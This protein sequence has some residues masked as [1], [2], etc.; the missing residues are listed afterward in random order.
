MPL[1]QIAAHRLAF[2]SDSWTSMAQD[3]GLIGKDGSNFYLYMCYDKVQFH[4]IFI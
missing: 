1:G 3:H 2:E 4:D